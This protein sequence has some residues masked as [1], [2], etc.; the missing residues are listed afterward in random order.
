VRLPSDTKRADDEIAQRALDI[1]KWHIG[2]PAERIAVKV[3]R[4]VVTLTG[5]V[6]WQYQKF[7]AEHAVHKLSGVVDV[8][9]QIRISAPVQASEVKGKVLRAL[10][11]SAE[12]DAQGITV[13]SDRGKVILAGEVRAWHERDLAERAAWSAVGVAA[14]ENRLTV[15]PGP[16]SLS[17]A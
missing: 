11:R 1:L 2:L 6:E 14:V 5:E 16:G 15:G 17:Q 10:E 4:G 3:E 13:Q 12:L 8:I 9:D 7:D